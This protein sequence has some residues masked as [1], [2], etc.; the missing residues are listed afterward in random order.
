[1]ELLYSHTSVSMYIAPDI[2]SWYSSGQLNE[3]KKVS[4]LFLTLL[5][6]FFLLPSRNAIISTIALNHFF[7]YLISSH[8]GDEEGSV[9]IETLTCPP[10]KRR[11]RQVEVVSI[12]VFKT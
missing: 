2:L 12:P 5:F 6:F 3:S 9:H 7:F 1:M 8:K 4:T 11:Y 10:G